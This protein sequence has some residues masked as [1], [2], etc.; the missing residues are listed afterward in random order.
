M[1]QDEDQHVK[2]INKNIQD[3][4]SEEAITEYQPGFD[5]EKQD[6]KQDKNEIKTMILGLAK[7]ERKQTHIQSFYERLLV[8]RFFGF[9]PHLG[10]KAHFHRCG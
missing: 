10:Q 3:V 1:Q 2:P 9:L 5:K 8:L 7:P 6:H 4:V